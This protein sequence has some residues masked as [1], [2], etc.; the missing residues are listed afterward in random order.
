MLDIPCLNLCD[1]HVLKQNEA[2]PAQSIIWTPWELNLSQ[3]VSPLSGYCISL[4]NLSSLLL[5]AICGNQVPTM[6]TMQSERLFYGNL[7]LLAEDLGNL[8]EC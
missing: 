3:F 4:I 5:K 6:Q 7:K 2:F 1:L 8:S